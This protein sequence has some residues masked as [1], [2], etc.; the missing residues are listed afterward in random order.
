MFPGQGLL[1]LV[2]GSYLLELF[3]SLLLLLNL[4]ELLMT[5]QL[6]AEKTQRC[7]SCSNTH[8]VVV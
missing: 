2:Q 1:V 7:L 6:V 5:E 3:E 8:I 4:F